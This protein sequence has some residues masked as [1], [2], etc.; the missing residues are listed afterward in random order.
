MEHAQRCGGKGAWR[1]IF[2]SELQES[3]PSM[4]ALDGVSY[5]DLNPFTKYHASKENIHYI[6]YSALY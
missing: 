3:I 4:S 5:R 2:I 1:G 6:P